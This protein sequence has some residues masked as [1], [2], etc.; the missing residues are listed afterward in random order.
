VAWIDTAQ[1][2]DIWWCPVYIP[3]V[4]EEQKRR[5]SGKKLIKDEE[6]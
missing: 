4:R 6:Y 2:K 3:D 5:T 1:E